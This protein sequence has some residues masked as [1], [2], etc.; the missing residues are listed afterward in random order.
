MAERKRAREHPNESSTTEATDEESYAVRSA[1]GVVLLWPRAAVERAGT[2]KDWFIT[3]RSGEEETGDEGAF[4]TTLTAKVL[5]TLRAA[6]AHDG[7]EATS[8]LA[9]LPLDE[10]IDVLGGA[11]FIE[12]EGVSTAASRHLCGT[13]LAGKSV[14]ELRSALGATN[15]LSEDEQNAALREPFHTPPAGV[16]AEEGGTAAAGTSSSAPPAMQ[17]SLSTRA[18]NDDVLATALQEADTTLLSRLKAV[19]WA[20]RKRARNELCWRV[21]SRRGAGQPAPASLDA[22]AELDVELL[23]AAGRLHEAAALPALA[24][25][26]GW[27]FVVDLQ[28]VR[29]AD[30][31]RVVHDVAPPPSPYSV[32]RLPP[33]P[34][35]AVLA[36]SPALHVCVAGEGEPPLELLLAAVACAASG[37]VL[38]IPVQQLRE[39][40]RSRLVKS[41]NLSGRRVGVGGVRLLALL[42]PSCRKL[43]SLK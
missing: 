12:A 35:D 38:R 42:L 28:A 19:S 43:V 17:R 40:R 7:D 18:G 24:R 25:L 22:I 16:G 34:A 8:P 39:G 27:G 37:E 41:A 29:Q 23:S 36:T 1:D 31:S 2:L 6:C 9:S 3:E 4:Q 5:E 11:N 13:L 26:H 33:P 14:D 21:V 32:L 30:L 10:T 20:W 15:D